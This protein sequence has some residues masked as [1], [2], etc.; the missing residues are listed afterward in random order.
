MAGGDGV[1]IRGRDRQVTGDRI[2]GYTTLPDCGGLALMGMFPRLM[3]GL[4]QEEA[5][6]PL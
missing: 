1:V 6:L 3:A 2:H 5:C 4:Y